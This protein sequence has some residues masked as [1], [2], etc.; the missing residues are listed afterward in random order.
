MPFP[1][2]HIYCVV[3]IFIPEF[4]FSVDVMVGVDTTAADAIRITTNKQLVNNDN[5]DNNAYE[6]CRSEGCGFDAY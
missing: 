3:T 4:P 2:H 5:N 6:M 1:S